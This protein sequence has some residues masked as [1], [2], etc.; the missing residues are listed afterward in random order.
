MIASTVLDETRLRMGDVGDDVYTE[1]EKL[2]ELNKLLRLVASRTACYKKQVD[3]QIQDQNMIYTLPTDLLQLLQITIEVVDGELIFDSS[4]A[5][6]FN[7]GR[8]PGALYNVGG[9]GTEDLGITTIH[10]PTQPWNLGPRPAG[11]GSMFDNTRVKVRFSDLVSHNE[12]MLNPVL[13]TATLRPVAKITY[14]FG[15]QLPQRDPDAGP[16]SVGTI[17]EQ[18]EVP[19]AATG[20]DLWIDTDDADKPRA[21]Y[22]CTE[23]YDDQEGTPMDMWTAV[24]MRLVYAATFSNLE[25]TA[26]TIPPS[27]HRDI[28]EALADGLA[29]TLIEM[30]EGGDR[31]LAD[32]LQMKFERAVQ[33]ALYNRSKVAYSSMRPG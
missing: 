27:I 26:A 14:N 2:S 9:T 29:A 30:D 6:L 15:S 5:S 17:H 11:N 21:I 24:T 16:I 7:A 22:R 10:A 3:V 18:D 19:D 8:I 23:T 20:N 33:Q 25:N 13:D 4:Y 31:Q 32:R 28:Q 1:A 12:I